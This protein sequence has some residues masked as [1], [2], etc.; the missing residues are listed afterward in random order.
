VEQAAALPARTFAD[1]SGA[2]AAYNSPERAAR[3]RNAR[4]GR[5]LTGTSAHCCQGVKRARS[6][7]GTMTGTPQLAECAKWSAKSLLE[8]GSASQHV[9]CE[10]C[11]WYA[12]SELLSLAHA[13]LWCV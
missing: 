13:K 11:G 9:L 7:A 6:L 3:R 8:P 5:Y 2:G 1:C 12:M 10:W 4:T